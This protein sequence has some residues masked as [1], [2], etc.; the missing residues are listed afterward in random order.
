M[1]HNS[2]EP[3]PEMGIVSLQGGRIHY[4][5]FKDTEFLIT[6]EHVDRDHRPKSTRYKSCMRGLKIT[7][8]LVA[9]V[10]GILAAIL[11]GLEIKDHFKQRSNSY[12]MVN[13]GLRIKSPNL[14]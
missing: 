13:G 4:K 7:A 3:Y 10:V 11:L 9:I 8:A 2:N 1:S 6:N 12:Q 14:C 5:A